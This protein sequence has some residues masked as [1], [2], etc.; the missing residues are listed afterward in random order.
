[1]RVLAIDQGTSA[2]K[3]VVFGEDS[4]IL[5]SVQAPVTP[6]AVAGGGVEQDPEQLW[7]SVI[8]AGREAVARSGGG[9]ATVGFANQGETVLAWDRGTGRPLSAAVSWQDRRA[10][11]ICTD[12]AGQAEQLTRTTGLPLDP[13][14]AAPK[15][16]WLRRNVTKDGVVTT[17]DA[18]L[19]HRLTGSYVT[20]ATTASR[21]MLLDLERRTWSLEACAAFGL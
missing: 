19:L 7:D 6:H 21:T 15:M 16:T 14:F 17:S 10:A 1:L 8:H 9:V 18:W 2:T 12:M 5:A 20:D 4:E 11:T 13:Y 3:A